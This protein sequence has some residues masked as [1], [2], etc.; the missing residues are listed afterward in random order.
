MKFLISA[1]Y[2]CELILQS[3]ISFLYISHSRN[4]KCELYF[5]ALTVSGLVGH[6]SCVEP[7]ITE[8]SDNPATLTYLCLLDGLQ[9]KVSS[10]GG[11]TCCLNKN[12]INSL[13]AFLCFFRCED[14]MTLTFTTG[15][16]FLVGAIKLRVVSKTIE[17]THHLC[18]DK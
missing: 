16:R 5:F 4:I 1:C 14:V 2:Q 3:V 8:Y 11:V 15:T 12:M 17:A 9:R 13:G 7:T 10:F 6:V 18:Y